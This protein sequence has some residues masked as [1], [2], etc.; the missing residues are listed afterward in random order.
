MLVRVMRSA[1]GRGARSAGD[2]VEPCVGD[3][4]DQLVGAVAQG[5]GAIGA[6]GGGPEDAEGLAVE[7]GFADGPEVAEI[8]EH[9]LAG[10]CQS[11][12]RANVLR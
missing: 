6:E 11:A 8:E 4:D 10:M 2:A 1:A 12:G 5:G 9:A 3:I 7:P